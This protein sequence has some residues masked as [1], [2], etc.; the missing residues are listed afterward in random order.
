MD[1]HT[2]SLQHDPL[3]QEFF[4]M[5]TD[6]QES[7][8]KD[9]NVSRDQSIFQED[10]HVNKEEASLNLRGTQP[11]RADHSTSPLMKIGPKL[12]ILKTRERLLFR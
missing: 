12:C 7:S 3:E 4:M 11:F 2:L 6:G 8:K 10:L 1:R 9:H 5:A